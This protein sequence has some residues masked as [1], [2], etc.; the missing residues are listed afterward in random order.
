MLS[1]GNSSKNYV[2]EQPIWRFHNAPKRTQIHNIYTNFSLPI[3]KE[4][5]ETTFYEMKSGKYVTNLAL[6][7][8]FMHIYKNWL[9]SK[10]R[11]LMHPCQSN[12]NLENGNKARFQHGSEAD[13]SLVEY[14]GHGKPNLISPGQENGL[15]NPTQCSPRLC[16]SRCGTHHL[17]QWSPVPVVE[18][19]TTGSVRPYRVQYQT[20]C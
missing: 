8:S 17:E 19:P 15:P 4:H 3:E 18:V 11:S 9:I 5:Q 16:G 1:I 2:V 10:S 12:H 7:G 14:G 20:V 13:S 6:F